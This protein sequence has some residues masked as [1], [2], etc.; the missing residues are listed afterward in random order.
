MAPN[1]RKGEQR[2]QSVFF[3][4]PIWQHQKLLQSNLK[5]TFIKHRYFVSYPFYLSP[6]CFSKWRW[7]TSAEGSQRKQRSQEVR[8]PRGHSLRV[9]PGK[10]HSNLNFGQAAELE[11]HGVSA[12]LTLTPRS[13]S[14]TL[15]HPACPLPPR[16]SLPDIY[17]SVFA[18][19]W[20]SSPH[21]Y[22][23]FRCFFSLETN[24]NPKLQNIP[25]GHQR[26]P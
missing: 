8:F 4:F 13:E 16:P 20:F 7:L 2:D 18:P 1:A 19:F 17:C 14:Q 15:P 12:F 9:L 23:F 10:A 24:Q 5:P 6:W 26:V 11:A 25:Y 21:C 22:C 3:F